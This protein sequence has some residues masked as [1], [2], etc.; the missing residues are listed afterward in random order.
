MIGL[1]QPLVI[2]YNIERILCKAR[3]L[4]LHIRWNC[5]MH[6]LDIYSTYS[7][8][9]YVYPELVK[10]SQISRLQKLQNQALRIVYR[11]ELMYLT[12]FLHTR[13]NLLSLALRRGACILRIVNM[14]L[15]R[16][17]KCC[18]QSLSEK[19]GPEIIVRWDLSYRLNFPTLKGIR[20][21]FYI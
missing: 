6:I 8:A 7:G 5:L 13:G 12:Y 10:T 16:E 21:R 20:S 18:S 9:W 11:A 4:I 1:L 15:L 2:M 17:M 14:N 3:H 19:T